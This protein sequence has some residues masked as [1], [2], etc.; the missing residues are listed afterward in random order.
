MSYAI[1]SQAGAQLR[2]GNLSTTNRVASTF[3]IDQLIQGLTFPDNAGVLELQITGMKG[4]LAGSM[5]ASGKFSVGLEA[6]CRE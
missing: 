6:T 3:L 5:N 2:I 4:H 1:Y